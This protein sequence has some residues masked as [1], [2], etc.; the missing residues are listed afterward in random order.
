M[1]EEGPIPRNEGEED[2]VAIPENPVVL[3]EVRVPRELNEVRY[4]LKAPAFTGEEAV[5]QFIQDCQDV[6]EVAQWPP[7]VALLKLTMALMDKARPYR[8]GPDI[9]G[10]FASVRARFGISVIDAR[11]HLQR[12]WRDPHTSLQE[13]CRTRSASSEPLEVYL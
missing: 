6:M 8:V 9:D 3:E 4:Q 1:V 13:P 10:I 2:N 11:A 7:R 5:E 12:L